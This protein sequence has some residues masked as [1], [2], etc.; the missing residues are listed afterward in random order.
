MISFAVVLGLLVFCLCFFLEIQRW[1]SAESSSTRVFCSYSLSLSPSGGLG[2]PIKVII[3]CSRRSDSRVWQPDDGGLK[4]YTVKTSGVGGETTLNIFSS[5]IFLPRSTIWTPGTGYGHQ[6]GRRPFRRQHRC[7][8]R[9][10]VPYVTDK[11]IFRLR[12]LYGSLR[13]KGKGRGNRLD[14]CCQL[15][16]LSLG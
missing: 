1:Q 2:L 15:A 7:P 14:V 9:K 12:Y 3:A 8:S 5:W 10:L 6:R 13:R 11:F 4:L 16:A